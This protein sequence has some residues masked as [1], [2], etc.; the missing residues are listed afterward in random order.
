MLSPEQSIG[1]TEH[2]GIYAEL[3]GE[4]DLQSLDLQSVAHGGERIKNRG[5]DSIG[6]AYPNLKTGTITVS[7][8]LIYANTDIFNPE[9]QRDFREQRPN[10]TIVH[11]RYTT[12]DKVDLMNAQ[13]LLAAP[14]QEADSDQYPQIAMANDEQRPSLALGHNGNIESPSLNEHE[15]Y[16]FTEARSDSAYMISHLV[17]ERSKYASWQETFTRVLPDFR[18]AFSLLLMTEEKDRL[19]AARDP[20]GIRPLCFGRKGN[21]WVIASQSSALEAGGATYVR[22]LLPGE[23]MIFHSDGTFESIIYAN[24][25]KP[26]LCSLELLYF[27]D[28][29]SH[30]NGRS[31]QKTRESLGGQLGKRLLEKGIN[32]DAVVPVPNSGV[33]AA[34]G[35]ARKIGRPIKRIILTNKNSLRSFIGSN[36]AA[37]KLIANN[38]H[39][40]DHFLLRKNLLQKNGKTRIILVDDSI[41]RGNTDERVLEKLF[42]EEK[43]V[44]AEGVDGSLEV[45]LAVAAPN[46]VDTCQLGT[47][48]NSTDELC[49]GDW[50]KGMTLDQREVEVAAR[51]GVQ[52]FTFLPISGMEKAFDDIT[53]GY[54]EK[55]LGGRDPM[56]DELPLFLKDRAESDQPVI[57]RCEASVEDGW[58]VF[59]ELE[60]LTLLAQNTQHLPDIFV[61]IGYQTYCSAEFLQ[62]VYEKYNVE[63]IFI[64]NALRDGKK[65]ALI[66][67][68]HGPVHK[69]EKNLEPVSTAYQRHQENPQQNP[70]SGVTALRLVPRQEHGKT[71]FRPVPLLRQEVPMIQEESEAEF[72][73]RMSQSVDEIVK[74]AVQKVGFM[75]ERKAIVKRAQLDMALH[76]G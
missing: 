41:V 18:G 40:I 74:V 30:I 12:A 46:I 56:K 13:P 44:H 49:V 73:R 24:V 76:T 5:Q 6:I 45:H 70:V 51:L 36:I 32:V 55:C 22:E 26:A 67:T 33:P 52:T 59:P 7:K 19:Y 68:S 48:I 8:D 9:T 23:L 75:R 37:R 27:A 14:G 1:L 66:E 15:H 39:R 72:R 47:A 21:G 43:S 61:M 28:K 10:R 4:S 71:V 65:N 25:E 60:F 64:D 3:A 54:C 2:C 29:E 58:A 57:V 34:E 20:W 53:D 63:L 50:S 17:Q 31:V 62:Q 69:I 42:H 16:P 11:T 38:K 35:V